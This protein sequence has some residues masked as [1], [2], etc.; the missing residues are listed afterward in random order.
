MKLNLIVKGNTTYFNIEGVFNSD[1]HTNKFVAQ[2]ESCSTD[3]LEIAFMDAWMLPVAIIIALHTKFTAQP[4]Q[5]IK[6]IVFCRYL[7]AYLSKMSIR[8]VNQSNLTNQYFENKSVKA[9]VIGGSAGSL[10]PILTI[11]SKLPLAEVSIFIVQHILEHSQNHLNNLISERSA[12]NVAVVKDGMKIEPGKVYIAPPA[13]H[14]IVDKGKIHLTTEDKLNYARPSIS[15]LFDS[16]A[17]EYGCN[18]IA[19]L[20]CGYGGDGSSSLQLLHNN[21]ATIIMEDPEECD[22]KDMLLN[23]WNTGLIDYKFPLPEIIS[24]LN[25]MLANIEPEI[26]DQDL[27]LF[28]TSINEKYGYNYLRYEKESIKRRIKHGMNELR[29]HSFRQFKQIVMNDDDVFEF[30]FLE[31]SINVTDLFRDPGMYKVIG[32]VILPYLESYPYIKIWSAG[33]STGLEPYSL[34]IKLEESGLLRKTQIYASDINPYVIEEAKNGLLPM[35]YLERAEKNY[36]AAGG[37]NSITDYMNTSASYIQIK[38]TILDKILFFQHSLLN[39]GIF[40]EFQLIVCR[41]V[42][43]YFDKELQLQVINLFI[44]S[45]DINGFL[46]LGKNE[47][48]ATGISGLTLIDKTNNIYKRMH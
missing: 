5:K 4:L 22:A 33:C 45:L 6:V 25:R 23:A 9:I 7:A 13:C 43:I 10:E 32:E 31:F 19:I 18:L 1:T 8:C 28:L 24:Y 38:N 30:L 36:L 14:L 37:V 27:Y 12:F 42:L 44:K 35:S 20:L 47:T 46:I 16:A 21:K 40:H 17:K 34:A 41:N 3:Y 48:F 29:I 2:L 15:R 39:S 26:T 11:M